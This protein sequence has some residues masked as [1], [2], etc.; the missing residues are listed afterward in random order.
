MIN[1]YNPL[2]LCDIYKDITFS[3]FFGRWKT[4]TY[5][6]SSRCIYVSVTV[7]DCQ[8]LSFLMGHWSTVGVAE[9]HSCYKLQHAARL[10]PHI[11]LTQTRRPSPSFLPSQ[12][13]HIPNT[14]TNIFSWRMNQ[15]CHKHHSI[16]INSVAIGYNRKHNYF[17]ALWWKQTQ[18]IAAYTPVD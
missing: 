12:Q 13:S 1:Q 3:M 14:N 10:P 8:W 16:N 11:G 15:F 18:H 4:G 5:R 7:N 17:T 2:T 9:R 6:T